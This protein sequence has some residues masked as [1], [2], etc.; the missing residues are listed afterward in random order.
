MNCVICQTGELVRKQVE[1]E[2]RVGNDVLLAP[3]ETLVCDACG[4][5]YYDRATMRRLE[6]LEADARKQAD[7]FP[8]VGRV[9]LAAA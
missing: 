1:E 9:L 6:Q 3:V 4:E 5:R 2:L 8:T 7:R